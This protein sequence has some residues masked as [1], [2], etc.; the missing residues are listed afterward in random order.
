MT[1]GEG[2]N[3]T[4]GRGGGAKPAVGSGDRRTPAPHRRF[5]SF[6]LNRALWGSCALA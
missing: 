6:G 3:V 5:S 2:V 1:S 4:P